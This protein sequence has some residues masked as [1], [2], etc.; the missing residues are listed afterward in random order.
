[1]P[2]AEG[3]G[4]VVYAF[5]NPKAEKAMPILSLLALVVLAT[6][7]TASVALAQGEKTARV[8]LLG[9]TEGECGNQ[10]LREGLREL[11]YREGGNLAIECRHGGGRYEGLLRAAQEMA[12]AKPD[13]MV[14]LT[15]LTA[16]AAHVATNRIPIVFIASSDPVVGG[17]AASFPHPGGNMTGLTYYSGE[18]NAKRLELLK[19][20]A[21]AVR[22]VAVMASAVMSQSVN[23]VYVRDVTAAAATLGLE[24]RVFTAPEGDDLEPVFAE[25][26][27]WKADAVYP[28]PTIIFAYQA[29]QIADLA[30]WRGLPAIHWYKPFPAMGGL[31]AYGVDYPALQR[32]AARYV[33]KILKGADPAGLPIEQPTQYELIV[34]RETAD[35]LGLKIPPSIALRA[36]RIIE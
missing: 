10:P 18:L 11:G 24:I 33:D 23:A 4:C 14:A 36:D 16:D 35:E 31:M 13:V 26:D 2:K 17:F 6:G 30:K 5:E 8:G 27:A 28:L 9:L 1:L 21:P 3:G 19:A 20:V 25:L 12:S 7:V 15:H 29:Q 34:N 22:R 32:R